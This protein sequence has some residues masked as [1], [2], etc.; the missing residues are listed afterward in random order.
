MTNFKH[1]SQ[2]ELLGYSL[3]SLEKGE[4]QTLGKHLLHCAECRNLLPM[5]SVERFSAIVMTDAEIIDSPQKEESESFLSSLVS[6]LKFESVFVLGAA[7]LIIVFS[8]SFLLW[9]NSADSS[10]EVVQT[11]DNESGSEFNFPSPLQSPMKENLESSTNS[12]RAASVPTPKNL[13]LDSPKSKSSKNNPSQDSKKPSLKQPNETISATRGVSARC[14][15]NQPI[16]IEFSADKEN[17]VFKWK[18]VPKAAKYHLYISDDEEILID[19]FETEAET[20]F[21]LRKPLDPLK[22]YKWKIIVTME[23]GQQVVGDSQKFTMK[24]FQ[25]VQKKVDTK[26]SSETRCSANG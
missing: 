25:T 1:L 13:R 17:F 23:N 22:T 16:R 21:V 3:G 9:L 12:N 26:K 8:F 2:S 14:G 19:E 4:S 6:F 10:R 7:G 20:S 15:E 18:A 5:P 11:F 24:D